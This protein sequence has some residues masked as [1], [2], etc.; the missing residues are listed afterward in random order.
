MINYLI[1]D[2]TNGN[3]FRNFVLDFEAIQCFSQ[4]FVNSIAAKKS[5]EKA[6]LQIPQQ[7]NFQL[8]AESACNSKIRK[9]QPVAESAYNSKIQKFGRMMEKCLFYNFIQY[10]NWLS[11]IFMQFSVHVE[12]H[13]IV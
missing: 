2:S 4:Q 3:K 11:L 1:M 13:D 6:L 9:F 12:L 7:T 10:K 5:K 8:V